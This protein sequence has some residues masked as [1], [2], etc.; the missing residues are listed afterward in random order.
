MR[1][2][3]YRT[4]NKL[5]K[6]MSNP[7]TLDEIIGEEG[8]L[9]TPDSFPLHDPGLYII[10][11]YTGLKDVNGKE[12]Y[13]GDIVKWKSTHKVASGKIR[14]DTVTWDQET[15]C[16]LLM[17]FIHELHTADMGIIGNIHQNPELVL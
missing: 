17:P 9:W 3:K 6:K 11:Q 13:E 1:R 15:A 10:M 12:I 2:V 8:E 5:I 4:W 7:F 16:Y 14:I